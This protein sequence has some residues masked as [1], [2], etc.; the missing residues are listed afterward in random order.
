MTKGSAKTFARGYKKRIQLGKTS[1]RFPD[2]I[3]SK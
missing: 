2:F 1:Y 3:N